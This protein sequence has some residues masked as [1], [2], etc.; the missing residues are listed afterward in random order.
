MVGDETELPPDFTTT[1]ASLVPT[2]ESVIP[3]K[4]FVRLVLTANA[5]G[6]ANRLGDE[7]TVLSNVTFPPPAESVRVPTSPTAPLNRCWPVVVTSEASVIVGESTSKSPV[8]FT[9]PTIVVRSIDAETVSGSVST[10]PIP[11][12]TV[13]D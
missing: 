8:V 11:A 9:G 5:S 2:A 12:A 4:A 10:L 13:N 7:S 3:V 1:S 6:S